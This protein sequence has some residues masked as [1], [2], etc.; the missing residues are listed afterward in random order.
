MLLIVMSFK[1][2]LQKESSLDQAQEAKRNSH[3]AVGC[4]L[5]LV[6]ELKF[7]FNFRVVDCYMACLHCA[8][9]LAHLCQ[10]QSHAEPE[11]QLPQQT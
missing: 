10:C 4:V 1:A 11:P 6:A 7:A 9:S 2:P 8:D 5:Q 3:G